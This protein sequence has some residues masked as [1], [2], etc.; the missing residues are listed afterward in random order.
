MTFSQLIAKV[1][2]R[3]S[4]DLAAN[5][6]LGA[7]MAEMDGNIRSARRMMAT[8]M[9]GGTIEENVSK[10][11]AQAVAAA[12][13]RLHERAILE[14]RAAFGGRKGRSAAK[15]LAKMGR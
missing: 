2:E 15:R 11:E 13:K 12:I 5:P 3:E 14:R 4:A 10:W 9:Y 6:L 8:Q 1:R 7:M